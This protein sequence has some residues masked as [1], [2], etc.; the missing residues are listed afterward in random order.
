MFKA[1][2]CCTIQIIT[3]VRVPCVFHYRHKKQLTEQQAAAQQATAPCTFESIHLEQ[4]VQDAL[5]H[6]VFSASYKGHQV[7]TKL[8]YPEDMHLYSTELAVYTALSHVQGTLVP[9]LLFAG[10]AALPVD[11]SN[12]VVGMHLTTQRLQGQTLDS[13]TLSRD[14]AQTVCT[15]FEQLQLAAPGFLHGDIRGPNIIMVMMQDGDTEMGCRFLDFGKSR[16]HGS[17][18]EQADE[19]KTLKQL[20]CII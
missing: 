16:L 20:L 6:A 8:F 18:E 7:F 13:F 4:L 11:G 10:R 14:Q 9:K 1:A 5:E 19:L 3:I 2:T 15:A 12:V 17:L